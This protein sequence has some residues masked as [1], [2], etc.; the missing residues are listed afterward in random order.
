VVVHTWR[1]GRG[2]RPARKGKSGM[3]ANRRSLTPDEIASVDDR[4][5]D[6]SDI[7]ELD[8]TFWREA[9]LAR[10]DRTERITLRVKRSG[11][12]HFRASGRSYQTRIHRVLESYM[13]AQ[14][15]SEGQ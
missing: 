15:G 13:K 2:R 11:L 9:E 6:F 1:D 10:P 5:I 8:A 14:R 12:D 3:N 7:P 4:A